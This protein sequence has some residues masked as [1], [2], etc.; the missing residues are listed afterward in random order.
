MVTGG[1]TGG[2][3][4]SPGGQLYERAG[5]DT[6]PAVCVPL[7]VQ[8]D[9]A[10]RVKAVAAVARRRR[11]AKGSHEFQRWLLP[12]AATRSE[13]FGSVASAPRFTF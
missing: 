9:N 3:H 7:L 11:T 6:G 2:A 4:L 5:S 1:D 10:M 12:I 13:L 8:A